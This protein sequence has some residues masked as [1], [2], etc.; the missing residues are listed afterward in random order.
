[1]RDLVII[2]A[3]FTGT[4][5]AVA[6][7]SRGLDVIVLRSASAPSASSVSAGLY[8][9]SWY[10]DA[11]P[12]LRPSIDWLDHRAETELVTRTYGPDAGATVRGSIETVNVELVLRRARPVTC[13]VVRIDLEPSYV[14]IRGRTIRHRARA[15]LIAGG[16]WT[17]E[18]LRL[19]G[20]REIGVK[21]LFGRALHIARPVRD[22]DEILTLAYSPYAHVT[23]RPLN[24][25][26]RRIGDTVER[27]PSDDHLVKLR[28]RAAALH[29]A[30]FA[31]TLAV[32][33]NRPVL[34]GGARA[35]LPAPRVAYATGGARIGLGLAWPLAEAALHL[36]DPWTRP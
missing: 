14:E 8:R 28:R 27:R 9:P 36:L 11:P 32:G 24:E 30:G 16:V 34:T 5:A 20:L 7:R 18:L 29:P 23:S 1:M 13:D 12:A 17:D 26:V 22:V 10:G 3:G 15:L 19:A 6:A 33:G 31:S 21:P 2:G 35:G 25:Y 4:A